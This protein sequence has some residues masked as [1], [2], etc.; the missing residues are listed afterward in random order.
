MLVYKKY[1][2]RFLNKDDGGASG[3]QA[4][5]QG[6]AAPSQTPTVRDPFEGV[7]LDDVDPVVRK[8]IE[9]S[10][11]QFATLQKDAEEAKR[12]ALQEKEQA[13][14]WQ[15]RYDQT[16]AQARRLGDPNGQG[17][18]ETKDD[19]LVKNME[20]QMLA[21]GV[22]PEVAKTQAPLMAK[23]M[24]S[25]GE[26]LKQEI[27]RDLAPMGHSVMQREAEQSW[28]QA[29]MQDQLGALRIPEIA[30]AVWEGVQA[31]INTG[32]P[33]TPA[34]VINLRNMVYA[35]QL[36]KGTIA[37]PNQPPRQMSQPTP[38]AYP[39][40]GG[41]Y[42]GAGA[43]PYLPTPPDPNAPRTVLNEDTRG[44]LAATFAK[45]PVKP[46]AFGGKPKR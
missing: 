45:F 33:V 5:Q 6:G 31:L 20:Q 43:M 29:M 34:T 30:T 46:A 41:S 39:S 14:K 12:I 42:P 25:Y 11:A 7:D 10:K 44:A 21:N 17:D 1:W 27:G 28:H 37:L 35:E 23:L 4:S 18:K 19:V 13:R 40:F 26:T 9:D 8:I 3:A 24:T 32:Q 2:M 36:E 38:P 16:V 22:A 15:G